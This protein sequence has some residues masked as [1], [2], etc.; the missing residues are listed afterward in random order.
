MKAKILPT[1]AAILLASCST[2]KEPLTVTTECNYLP[3]AEEL[4]NYNLAISVNL[5]LGI[6]PGYELPLSITEIN[7]YDEN[8]DSRVDVIQERN[9]GSDLTYNFFPIEQFDRQ[10]MRRLDGLSVYKLNET[11]RTKREDNDCKTLATEP[12]FDENGEIAD[13]SLREALEGE[14]LEWKNVFQE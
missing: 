12:L 6:F 10:P 1:L 4:T 13:P 2:V 9:I 7:A 14:K 5:N 3:D 11:L 8:L